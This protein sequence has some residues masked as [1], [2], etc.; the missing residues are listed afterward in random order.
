MSLPASLELLD[1]W[2]GD[3]D[4][5]PESSEPTSFLTLDD[6]VIE[7]EEHES[8]LDERPSGSSA[9]FKSS[10]DR[11]VNFL[12]IALN[13]RIPLIS[14][15]GEGVIGETLRL[16]GVIVMMIKLFSLLGITYFRH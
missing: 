6:L 7:V 4:L 1:M 10:L 5:N 9:K 13:S 8:V 3:M 14:L 11:R 12:L 16:S 2:F 15:K